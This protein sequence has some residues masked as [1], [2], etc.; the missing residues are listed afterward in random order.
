MRTTA[1]YAVQPVR[2]KEKLVLRNPLSSPTAVSIS[3]LR[4][5]VSGR[6]VAPDDPDYDQA[7]TIFYRDFG[8]RPQVI[9]QAA[10]AATSPAS[11]RWRALPGWS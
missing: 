1:Q 11:L 6:V 3:R 7:R 4:T 9:V 8:R 2:K 10:D 5:Q